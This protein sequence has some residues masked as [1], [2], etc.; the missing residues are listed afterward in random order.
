ME[1]ELLNKNIV[2][3]QSIM[4]RIVDLK[5]VGSILMN[6]ELS[7]D[8]FLIAHATGNFENRV[9]LVEKNGDIIGNV[10]VFHDN[11]TKKLRFGFFSCIDQREEIR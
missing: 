5:K 1:I 3:N 7:L 8:P 9:L 6:N 10:V 4:V 11:T 2:E